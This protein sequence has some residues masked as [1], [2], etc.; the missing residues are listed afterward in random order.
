MQKHTRYYEILGVS[1]VASSGEIK[2]GYRKMAMTW[3]PD[4]NSDPKASEKFKEISLAYEVLS[5]PEKRDIYDKLGE[6]GIVLM[7]RRMR[8]SHFAVVFRA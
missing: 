5:N 3:H 7:I 2:A 6:A 4:K 8:P 1:P